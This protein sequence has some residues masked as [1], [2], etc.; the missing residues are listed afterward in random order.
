MVVKRWGQRPVYASAKGN[1]SRTVARLA[2]R[3][4]CKAIREEPGRTRKLHS[5]SAIILSG[6]QRL[7]TM[8]RFLFSTGLLTCCVSFVQ[9]QDF[10]ARYFKERLAKVND[11]LFAWKFETTNGEYRVFLN[12]LLQTGDSRLYG[13]AEVDSTGWTKFLNHGEPLVKRYH[14]HAAFAQYPVVNV[15]YEAARAY[16]RWLT[17]KYN[18]SPKQSFRRVEFVLPTETEWIQAAQGERKN[19]IFPWGTYSL[20]DK[21]GQFLC[22]FKHVGDIAISADSAGNAQI[23]PSLFQQEFSSQNRDRAVYTAEARSFWPNDFGLYNMSGNASEMV[24]EG[25]FTK[26]GSWNSY[27]YYMQIRSRE[28]FNGSSPQVGFRVFMRVVE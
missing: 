12:E 27:G 7:P 25:S 17:G 1:E 11:S 4:R 6:D 5:A 10:S 15:S 26:G 28:S 2:L 19:V 24:N 21:Q 18:Q 22:N 3:L 8:K 16:C 14:R 9:A 23:N 13:S 20:R